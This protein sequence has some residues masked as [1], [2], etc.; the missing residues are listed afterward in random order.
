MR[1]FVCA[2]WYIRGTTY[3]EK[4]NMAKGKWRAEQ[5]APMDNYPV[6]M[7]AAHARRARRIG[8]GNLSE[9]V[10][11]A[12]ETVDGEPLERRGPVGDRRKK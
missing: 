2:P 6:R 9:G 3:Y 7:T 5:D 11:R 1:I 4:F 8:Q 12:L 10:R